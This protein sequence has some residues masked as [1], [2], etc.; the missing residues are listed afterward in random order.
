MTARKHVRGRRA[1]HSPELVLCEVR[2]DDVVERCRRAVERAQRAPGPE[3]QVVQ[4]PKGLDERDALVADLRERP[5]ANG[6]L[7]LALRL[8]ARVGVEQERVRVA[9]HDRATELAQSVHDLRRLG[10]ALDRVAEADDTV[11]GIAVEIREHR[12]ERDAVPVDVGDERG[13]DRMSLRP[14]Y[15]AAR[16]PSCR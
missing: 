12:V 7:T 1:E 8:R 15:A 10:A 9:E 3:G 14:R 13:A 6:E 2:Q 16:W 5:F 4:R 11:D